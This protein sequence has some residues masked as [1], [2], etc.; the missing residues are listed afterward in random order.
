MTAKES[1]RYEVVEAHEAP[2]VAETQ[3]FEEEFQDEQEETRSLEITE[4]HSSTSTGS[5]GS[6]QEQP[7]ISSFDARMHLIKGNL[8]P[9]CL[10]LPHAF[11][12]SGWLLGSGLF[13]VVAAQGIY[14]M[15]LLAECKNTIV[16]ASSS[17]SYPTG[18]TTPAHHHVNTFMD[19]A[20]VALGSKGQHIV[21]VFLFVLQTGVCCV[22]LSL[23]A[24]NLTAQTGWS[25]AVCV[26]VVTVALLGIV[27]LR[28]LKSL[29]WLS[30]TA[31]A[32]MVL[33]IVTAAI[34]GISEIVTND[35]LPAPPKAT[36]DGGD[37]AT[38]VSSMF[39]SFEGIGLV[40][41]VENSFVG[42][43]GGGG[44]GAGSSSSSSR[45]AT[46]RA[47]YQYRTRVLP[48]AM[49]TVAT[50]FLLIG[51]SASWGFPENT[52]GSI[53]AFLE[54]RYPDQPWFALVNS[55]VMVAVFLTF[56]LQLTPAMEVLEEWCQPTN[57]HNNT[58]EL[59]QEEQEQESPPTIR[60]VDSSDGHREDALL[61]DD[62]HQQ[63]QQCT[64]T[65]KRWWKEKQWIFRRY[66]VVLG[67]AAVVLLVDDLG[68]LMAL[69]GAVG[70]TGLALMPCVI[71]LQLQRQGIAP[72]HRMKTAMDVFTIAFSA[73]VMI[74]G[75]VVSVQRMYEK[76]RG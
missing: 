15:Y 25:N 42:V 76:Q 53:T 73:L 54:E 70:Q 9:G 47:N 34:A 48:G 8:G 38:F 33:A 43:G 37:V 71:H 24:T 30:T 64:T 21:Q 26:S 40:L 45:E 58:M 17:S 23:I 39:F 20:H 63:Q 65:L 35:A 36:S 69:F 10:N 6:G 19:V 29:R 50:L 32:F 74:F 28:F 12:L 51:L 2:L 49:G 41:P 68:L 14:S 67:C 18:T 61:E 46:T 60:R 7:R 5:A 44:G 66:L 4:A 1:Q 16:L 22:F 75:L 55:L 72:K 3:D 59:E 62:A 52:S 13:F 31:N 27:L 56:P 57:N 11:G